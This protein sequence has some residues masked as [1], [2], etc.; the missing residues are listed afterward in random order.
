[1]LRPSKN[2][3]FTTKIALVLML[4]MACLQGC[5]SKEVVNEPIIVPK[6]SL[7]NNLQKP[8]LDFNKTATNELEASLMLWDLY[9][10]IKELELTLEAAKER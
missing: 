6:M 3:L 9:Q 8:Q 1:M 4:L 5:T 10:Y 7:N 2:A